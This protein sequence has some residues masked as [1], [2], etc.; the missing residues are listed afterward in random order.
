M[1]YEEL[2]KQIQI[3]NIAYEKQFEVVNN[4]NSITVRDA[5]WYYAT[6]NNRM[7]YSLSVSSLAFNELDDNL[8][9]D[10]LSVV[11]EFAQTPIN[12]RRIFQRFY[13]SSKLTPKV[14]DKFLF[15][16]GGSV[17]HLAWGVKDGGGTEFTQDEIDYI[18]EKF[19]TDLS[20][21]NIEEVQE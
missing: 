14:D 18:C 2:K 3:L 19:H 6:I 13:I 5:D 15:K 9:H 1:I 16:F 11:Y 4:G 17:D 12:S 10:L 21:F 7:P 8:R 20:D